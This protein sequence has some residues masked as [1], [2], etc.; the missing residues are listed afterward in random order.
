MRRRLLLLINCRETAT[1]AVLELLASF[2]K[3]LY[4]VVLYYAALRAF[5]EQYAMLA[6]TGLVL[7]YFIVHVRGRGAHVDDLMY[8]PDNVLAELPVSPITVFRL[9]WLLSSA[10]SSAATLANFYILQLTLG[11][12]RAVPPCP[13]R[14]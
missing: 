6:A 5:S 7:N 2:L 12:L 3:S 1:D 11:H 9:T 14:C 4:M 10:I 13:P 8:S